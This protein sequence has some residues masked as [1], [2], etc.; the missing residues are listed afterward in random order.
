MCLCND[1]QT[2]KW[3]LVYKNNTQQKIKLWKVFFLEMKY[4]WKLR[5]LKEMNIAT[6]ANLKKKYIKFKVERH[7]N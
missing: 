3:N 5:N 1:F 4:K 7:D 2:S 6:G